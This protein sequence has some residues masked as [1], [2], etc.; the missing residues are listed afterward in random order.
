MSEQTGIERDEGFEAI[1]EHLKETRGFDFTG[2]KRS[3]LMRR[4]S[5]R[6]AQV[7]AD[8]YPDYLDHLQ[9][10]S[11]EFAALFNTILINVTGFFRDP[12]AWDYL[13]AEVVPMLLAERGPD[14]QVRI[15]SAGCS[16]GEEA[17]SLAIVLAEAMGLEEFRQRVKIYATDVDEEALAQARQATYGEKEIESLPEE[18]VRKYF[19]RLAGRYAFHKDLRRSVIFGRNDLVQDAPI[20]RIDLL[21]CRNTLMYF[22]AETQANILRK[23]HFALQPRG[24]LF[25]GKAEM[26]LSHSRLFDPLDLRHRVFRKVAFTP[27][28]ASVFGMSFAQDQPTA[29]TEADEL[30][31]LAFSASPVAQVVVNSEDVVALANSQAQQLFGLS[32]RDIGRPL[33]DLELSYRPVELRGYVA[34]AREERRAMRVKDVEWQRGPGEVLV[35]ELHV[36]PLLS[37]SDEV[38]G[39]S[40]VF[41]DVTTSHRLLSELANANR[42]RENA[43]EEL[44]STTEEL[45]TTNEE[46]QST[47]EELET[48]NEELQSTNEELE[49]TNEELH[50]TN[51]ELQTINNAL[52][53]RTSELDDVNEFLESILTSLRAGVVV[54][55]H[56]MRVVAWNSG[57]EELWGLRNDE[58]AGEHLLNLDIGLPVAEL[59]PVVR[60]ALADPA[61]SEEIVL[62]AVNRRGRAV[63]V[64]VACGALRNRRGE[65]TGA[66][67]VMETMDGLAEPAT[68]GTSRTSED[69]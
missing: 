29:V 7:G 41:H 21:L 12:D 44:Q 67:L 5:R 18:Y 68:R 24:V 37:L 54:V 51:D 56:Q 43:Y 45:E 50:S 28:G 30:R 22:T 38:I 33:P 52:R 35:L 55:D 1:L 66:I 53:D 15:W 25:M 39:V 11:D 32:E 62:K 26:L 3:S 48:T 17:Y 23:L 27:A 8:G 42:A 64:R 10:N 19:E 63:T 13:Q 57:A 58:A 40:V 61:Y 36:S 47:V 49:T 46:L 59:R 20:S 65:S 60:P 34:Q 69:R 9:A 31:A 4:V 16:S 14:D 6:M 2:Y